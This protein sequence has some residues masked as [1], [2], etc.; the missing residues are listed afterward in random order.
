MSSAILSFRSTTK[1]YRHG[2]VEVPAVRGVDLDLA[3]GTITA[4]MGPS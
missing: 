4:V 1:I 3:P 2:L